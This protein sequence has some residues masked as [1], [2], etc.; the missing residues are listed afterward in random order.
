MAAPDAGVR[1]AV[2]TVGR[3]RVVDPPSAYRTVAPAGQGR[4]RADSGVEVKGG[5]T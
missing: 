5:V 4:A 2:G 3:C 1:S